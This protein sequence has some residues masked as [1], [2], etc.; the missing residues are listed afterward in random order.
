MKKR[1]NISLSEEI[2]EQLKE[3]AEKSHRN[4]SQWITDRVL[5]AVEA[6]NK[7]IEEEQN[8]GCNN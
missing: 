5:E 6:N 4:V 8:N 7:T 3:V 1:V 2:A